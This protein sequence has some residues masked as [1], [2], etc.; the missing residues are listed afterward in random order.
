MRRRDLIALIGGAVVAWPLVAHPQQTQQIPKIGL[1]DYAPFW[2]P[3]QEAL[4]ELGYVEHQ[5]VIFEYRPT[6][7]KRETLS[8]LAAELVHLPVDLI[9]TFGAVATLAASAAT[10]TIPIVMIGVGDPRGIGIVP[11]LARPG[12]NITGNT[13][14]GAEVG[15]KRLDLLR[16]MIPS[17]SRVAFLWN[18]SNPA[19]ALHFDA[20]RRG[21]AEFGIEVISVPVPTPD[22]FDSALATMLMERPEALLMTADPMHQLH[23]AQ[24]IEFA[25]KNHLPTMHQLREH[26][27]AGGLMAYGASLP[28]LFRRG[29]LYVDKILKG[30]KPADL[31][32]EQPTKFEL[33]INLKTAEALGL[34][35][36][37][38]LLAGADEVIE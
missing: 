18:S 28:E 10:T 20:I 6:H 24:V 32:V 4:R 1:L 23:A 9:V 34:T 26:A 14:L 19:N 21:A 35:V 31:P 27:Q 17:A 3:L 37:P 38:I 16:Q 13:I 5:N 2:T 11:S 36:P 33:V 12:A 8:A 15:G 25:A 30:A 22:K 29:G 7:D